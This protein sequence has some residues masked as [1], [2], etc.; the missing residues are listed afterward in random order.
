MSQAGTAEDVNEIRNLVARYAD[1]VSR[2]DEKAWAETWT[3]E[4]TRK[5]LSDGFIA[6]LSLGLTSGGEGEAQPNAETLQEPLKVIRKVLADE[7]MVEDDAT[8]VMLLDM[9]M[10][11]L[12]DRIEIYRLQA[13]KDKWEDI[14]LLLDLRYKADRRLIETI[15]ALKNT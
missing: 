11:A 10:N 1:A 3:E 8:D 5:F 14:D 4:K 9:V 2:R 6:T 13:E 7:C 12:A 15:V